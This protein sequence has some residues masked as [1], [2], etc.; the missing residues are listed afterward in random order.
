MEEK[1]W[2]VSITYFLATLEILFE[3]PYE[4]D[5]RIY[6][7]YALYALAAIVAIASIAYLI[8]AII[9][10]HILI[11]IFALILAL[12]IALFAAIL[13]L[14]ESDSKLW[15]MEEEKKEEEVGARIEV[16]ESEERPKPLE[17][18]TE[19]LERSCAEL[20]V[21]NTKVKDLEVQPK[22][23]RRKQGWKGGRK[24]KGNQ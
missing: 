4:L 19:K 3:D 18:I 14:S 7:L 15:G 16:A 1:K 22:E 12:N 21:E 5:T 9:L 10:V 20:E 8:F 17:E 6:A 2:L 24:R 13:M 11:L 23:K